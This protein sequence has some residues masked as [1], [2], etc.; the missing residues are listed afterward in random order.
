[1]P[2]KVPP[3]EAP[4][5]CDID[6]VEVID[7]DELPAGAA[8][9]D[10]PELS[11]AESTSVPAASVAAQSPANWVFFMGIPFVYFAE[12]FGRRLA[13]ADVVVYG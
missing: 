3:R 1:M 8:V 9:V 12:S 4:I 13:C 5:G 10:E 6:I 7:I 2:A 11:H